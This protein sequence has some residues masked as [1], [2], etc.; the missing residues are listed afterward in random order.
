M[1]S[2][3]R[4]GRI[5][6]WE[7]FTKG[8]WGPDNVLGSE[9]HFTTTYYILYLCAVHSCMYI[10]FN[11]KNVKRS[12]KL[13]STTHTHKWKSH[14]NRSFYNVSDISYFTLFH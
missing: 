13:L 8:F 7:G 3:S 12:L 10:I 4:D 2:S 5:Y 1:I 6:V 11:L 9:N 14:K